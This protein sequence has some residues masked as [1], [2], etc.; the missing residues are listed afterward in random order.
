MDRNNGLEVRISKDETTTVMAMGL[1]EIPPIITRISL[2]DQTS[3]MGA[4][5]QT[6][7]DHLINAQISHSKE[8]M[9]IDLGMNLITIRMET[10]ETME[11]FPVLHQTKDEISHRI[12]HIDNQEVI[13]LTALL[14]ADPTLDLQL[15]L[16]ATSKSFHKTIIR[17]HLTW[18]ASPLPM[19]SL[20]NYQTSVR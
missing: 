17:H 19:I 13:N 10:G 16:H 11:D 18:F 12:I 8:A 7:E 15:V 6:M 14:S 3:H 2:Q 5:A 20:M 1:G 4:I 9:E